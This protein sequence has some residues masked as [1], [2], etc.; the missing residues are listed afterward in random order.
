MEL[1]QVRTEDL[2]KRAAPYNPRTISHHDLD[3]L[4]RSLRTFGTVEPIVVNRRSDRIVGGHQRVKAAL[5]EG[6]DTL[7]VVY[8]DLDESG[9]RQ[10]NLA[11]NRIHGEWD[12]QKLAAL[13][14]ELGAMDVDL[15]LTGFTTEEIDTLLRDAGPALDAS[16]DPD[17]TPD[18]PIEPQ[19]QPGDLIALGA[20]RLLCGS[21]TKRADIQQLLDGDAVDLLLTDPPYNVSY[22]GGTARAL[23]IANDDMAD[24]QYHAFMLAALRIARDALRPGASFYVWHA[25]SKGLL[26]RQAVEDAGLTVRQ[27]LVWSKSAFVMGRQDYHW[28][29]EPCLYGWK[30]GH[31]HTWTADRSQSTV[32]TCDRPSRNDAHP[33]MKPV[34]LFSRLIHNSTSRGALV[35]DPFAGSGTTVIAAE[36]LGRRAAVVEIDPAYCDVIVQRWQRFTGRIAAGWRGN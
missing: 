22:T 7:P 27:C 20:H 34:E 13:L 17:L 12:E 16:T 2:A 9:E 10:L 25:D 1:E 21:A 26:V 15:E 32:L 11:L 8:V 6:I 28:Q 18:L 29:H 3:A 14:T 33:T 30:D 19:T 31:A 5:A 23:T 24:P 36:L 35:L 4:R